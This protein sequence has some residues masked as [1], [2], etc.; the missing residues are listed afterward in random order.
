MVEENLKRCCALANEL[1]AQYKLYARTDNAKKSLDDLIDVFKTYMNNG[2][3]IVLADLEIKAEPGSVVLGAMLRKGNVYE[4]Y[5]VADDEEKNRRFVVC[6]E[7]FQTLLDDPA[8]RNMH[9][10]AHVQELGASGLFGDKSSPA[11]DSERSAEIAAM[12]FLYP[13]NERVADIAR[14]KAGNCD[15]QKISDYYGLPQIYVETY[16]NEIVMN[17]LQTSHGLSIVQ[18]GTSLI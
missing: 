15:Y 1:S 5:I 9:L 18:T 6:K 13:Y 12:Q 4:I 3:S 16:L 14:I 7:L 2:A 8:V 17:K 10:N 11:V